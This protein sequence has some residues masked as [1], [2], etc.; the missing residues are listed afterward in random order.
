MELLFRRLPL[1]ILGLVFGC[2]FLLGLLVGQ[3]HPSRPCPP[4]QPEPTP[5]PSPAP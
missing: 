5:P 1:F 4:R 3:R 2:G